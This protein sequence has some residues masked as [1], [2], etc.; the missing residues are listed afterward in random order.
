L[1]DPEA[2]EAFAGWLTERRS[3]LTAKG[4][5]RKRRPPA[6]DDHLRRV[7]DLYT[8]AYGSGSKSPAKDVEEE[9]RRLGE[10]RLSTKGSRVQVRQWIR[11][12]RERGYI[13]IN[14]ESK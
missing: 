9:L 4:E 1:H 11:R 12:A 5:P 2:A 10:P 7:A 14:G 3:M 6:D 8:A 13:T